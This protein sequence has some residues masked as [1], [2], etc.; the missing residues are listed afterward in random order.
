MTL[1]AASTETTIVDIFALVTGIA[2]RANNLSQ[3]QFVAVGT[4]HLAM[5]AVE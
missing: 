3:R 1:V 5:R 4:G 2:D